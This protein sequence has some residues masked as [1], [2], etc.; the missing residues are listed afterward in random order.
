MG[1]VVFDNLIC[2]ET[3]GKLVRA[4]DQVDGEKDLNRVILNEMFI[5]Q[6]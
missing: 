3:K 2:C 6:L 4:M 1:L 5:A